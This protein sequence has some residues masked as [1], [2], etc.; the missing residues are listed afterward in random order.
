MLLIFDFHANPDPDPAF[1][2]NPDPNPAFRSNLDPEPDSASKNNVFGIK[3]RL[4]KNNNDPPTKEKMNNLFHVKSLKFSVSLI[5]FGGQDNLLN[6]KVF[7]S[8][9]VK[10]LD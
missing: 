1:R 9:V 5:A 8:L 6:R 4:Q 2:S 10:I 3:Y 7:Q